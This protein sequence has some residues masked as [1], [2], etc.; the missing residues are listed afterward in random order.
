MDLRSPK[1]GFQYPGWR[2]GWR[3]AHGHVRQRFEI[4]TGLGVRNSTLSATGDYGFNGSF[5][6]GYF[7][8]KRD[9]LGPIGFTAKQSMLQTSN[10]ISIG[11]A[12]LN[13]GHEMKVIAGIGA[14]GFAA[15]PYFRSRR[16]WGSSRDP[17]SA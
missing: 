8:K 10:G 12:G 11:A 4:K 7:G 9:V 14:G 3:A 5:K 2:L 17:T 15:G 6:V 13:M 16:P 1:H